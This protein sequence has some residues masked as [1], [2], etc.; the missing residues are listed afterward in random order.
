[1]RTF[2]GCG[3]VRAFNHLI[4]TSHKL[5]SIAVTSIPSQSSACGVRPFAALDQCGRSSR[6]RRDSAE[7]P[8]NAMAG[9]GGS[10]AGW[11][12]CADPTHSRPAERRAERPAKCCRSQP[13]APAGRPQAARWAAGRT[14]HHYR[15][16]RRAA[17]QCTRRQ[18]HIERRQRRVL[19]SAR[20]M[21]FAAHSKSQ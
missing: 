16:G 10:G 9:R 20:A 19:L 8:H 14:G 3:G 18:N 5:Y 7:G 4:N 11:R 15:S 17:A 1:V 21:A 13:S 6:S 2:R 12:R